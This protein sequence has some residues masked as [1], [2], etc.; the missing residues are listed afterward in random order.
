MEA[1]LLAAAVEV[2]LL[3]YRHH[4]SQ[5]AHH[6]M[7]HESN[8]TRESTSVCALA[9]QFMKMNGSHTGEN[10]ATAPGQVLVSPRSRSSLV[11]CHV[12]GP[13]ECHFPREAKTHMCEGGCKQR[14]KR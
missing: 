12:V 1:P 14:A 9:E 11:L 7:L 4:N 2:A 6:S 8:S 3:P 13:T 10:Q 5:T